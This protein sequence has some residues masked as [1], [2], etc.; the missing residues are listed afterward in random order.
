MLGV[1]WLVATCTI[2]VRSNLGFDMWI[3]YASVYVCT[4]VC[5]WVNVCVC[6]WVNVCVGVKERIVLNTTC[7]TEYCKCISS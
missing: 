5:T 2:S 1:L 3:F 4:C 6:V 7:I